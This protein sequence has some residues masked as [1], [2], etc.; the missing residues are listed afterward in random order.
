MVAKIASVTHLVREPEQ[1]LERE[2]AVAAHLAAR[3]IPVV[4]ASGELP[5]TVHRHG[6]DVMTFWRHEPHA[7][8]VLPR[9]DELAALLIDLHAALRNLA[10]PP[11]WLG[12]PL[13]D[14]ARFLE[15]ARRAGTP[16]AADVDVLAGVFERLRAALPP[17]APDDQALHGDPHPG[18]LLATGAGWV[19]CDLEDT[20]SGPLE[21][22]LA[23][24]DGSTRLDGPAA[25]KAYGDRD[26]GVFRD[27]RRLHATVWYCLYAE[28]DA[29]QRG[30]AEALLVG[31]RA[32]PSW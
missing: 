7:A 4:R 8:D 9:P 25:V 29:R 28:T 11:P 10:E 5:A 2:L 22:D 21:W 13:L 14:I 31:W 15:H 23:C 3:G 26:L 30:R 19:W 20:C 18:N 32:Q 6:G 1:W 16:A 12:T 17:P 27:L 24:V